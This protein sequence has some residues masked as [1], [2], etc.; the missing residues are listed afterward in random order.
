MPPAIPVEP[1]VSQGGLGATL[2]VADVFLCFVGV[3]SL[4]LAGG[5]AGFGLGAGIAAALGGGP[6]TAFLVGAT[7][8]GPA[9]IG[10]L[11]EPGDLGREP[12]RAARPRLGGIHDAASTCRLPAP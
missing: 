12:G 6:R 7:G 8:A 10:F 1:A 2:L 11:R 3:R 4:K 9:F 5:S